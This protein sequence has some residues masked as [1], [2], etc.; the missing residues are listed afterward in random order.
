M[1]WTVLLAT[2][3]LSPVRGT[4]AVGDPIPAYCLICG[5]RGTA[6]AALNLVLFAPLGALLAHRR[7]SAVAALL[8]GMAFSLAIELLQ[9]VVPGRYATFG[10][11]VWNGLGAAA[12]ALAV[13]LVGRQA[14]APSVAVGRIVASVVAAWLVLAGFLL[15][16][17]PTRAD[18]YGQWTAD[19]GYMP[20]YQGTLLSAELDGLPV[21][22]TRFADGARVTERLS[23]DWALTARIVKGPAPE[24]VSPIVSIYDALEA[25]ILLL[26]AH[27]E[28]LVLRERTRAKE[29][30]LD[31][32]DLRLPDALS[33]AAA[34]DTLSIGASRRGHDRC[35]S[36]GTAT[37]CALGFTPGRTWSLLLHPESRS[38]RA[39]RVLDTLWM[40][41]L[42]IPV[43][44]FAPGSRHLAVNALL[45]AASL[46]M[47]VGL[48]RLMSPPWWEVAAAL[49]GLLSG[50]LLIRTLADRARSPG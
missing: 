15:E 13:H 50:R 27:G 44:L 31:H 38:E 42:L 47:G 22:D 2:L 49:G 10:D 26:G 46:A 8:A 45:V 20:P 25:E 30:F 19:L 24:S 23:G 43:G 17:A 37:H 48:T 18:Y 14:A 16:H 39:R 9:L 40:L 4:A 36:V 29:L 11:V 1:G 3:T 28:D 41:S 34:G 6:D 7:R 12:G 35:L 33:V 21:P 32:P 5:D